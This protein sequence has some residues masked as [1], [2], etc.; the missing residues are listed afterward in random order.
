[1]SPDRSPT[2]DP[3]SRQQEAGQDCPGVQVAV[4][5]PSPIDTVTIE[6][7]DRGPE[8]HFHAGGQGFWI[9][10]WLAAAAGTRNVT[11]HGLGSGRR[12]SLEAIA[13]RIEIR[14]LSV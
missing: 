7:N 2:A 6:G 8:V 14:P 4:L 5:A 10:R 13:S 9:V 1:M 12:G 3:E 11:R